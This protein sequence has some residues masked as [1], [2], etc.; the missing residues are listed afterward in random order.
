MTT[1]DSQIHSNTTQRPSRRWFTA[2]E[3]KP[4]ISLYETS[5]R[6]TVEFARRSLDHG[7]GVAEATVER[8]F[9]C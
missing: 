4:L 2:R 7:A 1:I 8:R 3:R 5:G 6:I 9:P